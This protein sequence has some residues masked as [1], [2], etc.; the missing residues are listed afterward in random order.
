MPHKNT[1]TFLA[2][3]C[4]ELRSPISA[5]MG[6]ADILEQERDNLTKD[7]YI[8]FV[9]MIK[10]SGLEALKLV[11]DIM[12]ISKYNA[13][14]FS[15]DLSRKV[16][17]K[18][19][20]NRCVNLKKIEA[21][22]N[23]IKIINN[24][25]SSKISNINLDALRLKQ[26]F[27]NLLSNAIKY[28]PND[29]KITIDVNDK[30]SELEISISDQGFGMTDD[31]VKKALIPYQTIKNPNSDKVDAFGLGLPCVKELVELQN[32]K[33]LIESKKNEGTKVILIFKNNKIGSY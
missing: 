18:E 29:S 24:S 20:I 9:N 13:D 16:D 26:I 28:S 22:Q 23:N 19:I 8:E 33:M 15:I 21:E 4:H 11:E 31:E 3:I 25:S 12:A 14:N 32:G 10:A 30:D 2:T 7:Q 5:M 6:C 17:I 1:T 27:V